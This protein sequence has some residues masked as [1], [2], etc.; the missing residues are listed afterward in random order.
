[1]PGRVDILLSGDR[2]FLHEELQITQI[3]QRRSTPYIPDSRLIKLVTAKQN[4]NCGAIMSAVLLTNCRPTESSAEQ[5]AAQRSAPGLSRSERQTRAPHLPGSH[6]AAR[7]SSPWLRGDYRDAR[8]SRRHC[9]LVSSLTDPSP[10]GSGCAP[11]G[12]VSRSD[13]EV[14]ALDA[15]YVGCAGPLRDPAALSGSR[16]NV[17]T[18][19]CGPPPLSGPGRPARVRLNDEAALAVG[20]RR[21]A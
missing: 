10:S 12:R 7:A 5:Y 6:R 18:S 13:C 19:R 15:T 21:D 3:R 17:Q 16:P 14:K 20:V 4:K 8:E 11:V 9:D 2:V 1:M